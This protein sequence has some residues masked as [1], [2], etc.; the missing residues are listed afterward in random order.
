MRSQFHGD[1]YDVVVE[2]VEREHLEVGHQPQQAACVDGSAPRRR[3]RD[4]WYAAVRVLL[5]A[6]TPWKVWLASVA[7]VLGRLVKYL[8]ERDFRIVE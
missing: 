3:C 1:A 2:P 4:T 6:D 5:V 7:S 8:G